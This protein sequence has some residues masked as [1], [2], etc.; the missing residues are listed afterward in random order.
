MDE[1]HPKG[2]VETLIL[3]TLN[4][5]PG[6]KYPVCFARISSFN[7]LPKIPAWLFASM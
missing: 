5:H 7:E 6:A 3:A 2:R 4:L 1:L